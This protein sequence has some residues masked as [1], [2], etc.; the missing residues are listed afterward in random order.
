M[1]CQVQVNNSVLRHACI[2]TQN[3]EHIC[4]CLHVS[5]CST[6]ISY[7]S[8]PIDVYTEW[9]DAAEAENNANGEEGEGGGRR[10][11]DE[12]DDYEEDLTA[13]A[14]ADENELDR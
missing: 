5:Q 4:A 8:E 1:R 13:T 7:L 10:G 2:H 12:D 14:G 6:G 3:V 9:I 11:G